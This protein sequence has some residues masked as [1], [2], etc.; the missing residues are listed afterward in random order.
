MSNHH[1]VTI[2]VLTDDWPLSFQDPLSP[3]MYFCFQIDDELV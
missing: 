3:L 1:G 2:Y